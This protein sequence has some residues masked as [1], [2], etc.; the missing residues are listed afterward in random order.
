MER[1]RLPFE[2]VRDEGGSAEQL[3]RATQFQK[4]IPE[5]NFSSGNGGL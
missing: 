2:N 5:F 4:E 3:C 1:V